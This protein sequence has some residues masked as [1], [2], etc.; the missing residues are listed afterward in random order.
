MFGFK[1]TERTIN[2]LVDYHNSLLA[3]LILQSA[4]PILLERP[5]RS[6]LQNLVYWIEPTDYAANRNDDGTGRFS[7][8]YYDEVLLSI[9]QLLKQVPV[10]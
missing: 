2:I 10:C 6:E 1:L 9:I 4:Y 8:G 3:N 5:T 7:Y